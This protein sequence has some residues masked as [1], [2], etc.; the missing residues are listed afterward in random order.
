[1]R[2][3]IAALLVALAL[4]LLAS[5]ATLPRL[6]IAEKPFVVRGTGF[7]PRERIKLTLNAGGSF[8]R[9]ILA[10]SRGSFAVRFVRASSDKCNGYSASALGSN[11][12]RA[13][14]RVTRTC[15]S[16]AQDAP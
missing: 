6:Q 5:A 12:S 11:G 9:T 8:V 7:Q 13:S 1:M 2:G 15:S 4:P 3:V 10:S 14:V 16:G